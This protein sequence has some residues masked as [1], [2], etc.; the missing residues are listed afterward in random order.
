M[1]VWILYD[2]DG[3][4][5]GIYT[6]AGKEKKDQQLYEEAV[7]C[8]DRFIDGY[9]KEI[10]E[11]R[12]LRQ[13]YI[14]DAEALIDT[15]REAKEKLDTYTLKSTRKQRKIALHQAEQLTWKIKG[16]K[17]KILAMQ[18]MTRAEIMNHYLSDYY[19]EDH[20]VME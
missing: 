17:D 10:S 20:Y 14:A 15:E 19:W 4:V 6:E 8:R 7:M 3:R 1:K 16:L 2:Y 18:R 9:N 5:D 11:L 13:P 12:E